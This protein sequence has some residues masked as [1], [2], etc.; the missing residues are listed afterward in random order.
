[1]A[2]A[3][4]DDLRRKMLEVHER[5]EGTLEDLAERFCVSLGWASKVS[6]TYSRTG[7]MERPRGGK[8]G[9]KSKVTAEI[10]EFL[11]AAVAAKSDLILEELKALLYEKKQFR[12]S[13]G[14]LWA[15][16]RRLGLSLK[17]NSARH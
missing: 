15:A 16:L 7:Q 8:R 4:S 5:G 12:I 6:A 13:I 10:D 9:R 11:R 3:Y 14:W 2:K 1:M 17:K